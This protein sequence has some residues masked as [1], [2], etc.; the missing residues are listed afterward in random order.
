MFG[1]LHFV[2]FLDFAPFLLLCMLPVCRV[3]PLFFGGFLDD[4]S[5]K[6]GGVYVFLMDGDGPLD[7]WVLWF[8]S[9]F[10]L[11]IFVRMLLSF[12]RIASQF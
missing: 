10:V 7:S 3:V 11:F 1:S 2:G 4:S 8:F 6:F 5:Q 9:R 12:C